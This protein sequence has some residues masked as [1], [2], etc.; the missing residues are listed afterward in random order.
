MFVINAMRCVVFARARYSIVMWIADFDLIDQSTERIIRSL[1]LYLVF[2]L[3]DCTDT[4]YLSEKYYLYI[5][6]RDVCCQ[7]T[8]CMKEKRTHGS[9]WKWKKNTKKLC[10]TPETSAFFLQRSSENVQFTVGYVS[11]SKYGWKRRWKWIVYVLSPI[12]YIKRAIHRWNGLAHTTKYH[13]W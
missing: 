1:I 10:T 9:K 5:Y 13:R 8:R 6:L 11:M 7:P 12:L 2:A 3:T 4:F